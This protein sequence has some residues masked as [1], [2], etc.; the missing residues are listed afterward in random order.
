VQLKDS[1]K[2]LGHHSYRRNPNEYASHLKALHVIVDARSVLNSGACPTTTLHTS[3]HPR[4]ITQLTHHKCE[5]AGAGPDWMFLH[6]IQ[7]FTRNS[8]HAEPLTVDSQSTR[9]AQPKSVTQHWQPC[10]PHSAVCW[11]PG[12][13]TTSPFTQ[14]TH[15]TLRRKADRLP[16]HHPPPVW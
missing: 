15:N 9:S 8:D 2:W 12:T 3:L 10:K 4:L 6:K 5:C 13:G 14:C 11:F 16:G 7:Q 1:C